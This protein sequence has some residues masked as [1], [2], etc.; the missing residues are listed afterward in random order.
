[1]KYLFYITLLIL[2]FQAM[3]QINCDDTRI[4]LSTDI[5]TTHDSISKDAP[6]HISLFS[7]IDNSTSSPISIIYESVK[8][9]STQVCYIEGVDIVKDLA[10][11]YQHSKVIK[12]PDCNGHPETRGLVI[13]E[14]KSRSHGYTY[15]EE[16]NLLITDCGSISYENSRISQSC[17]NVNIERHKDT[18]NRRA[19]TAEALSELRKRSDVIYHDETATFISGKVEI[20]FH[21][22]ENKMNQILEDSFWIKV[23]LDRY[24]DHS[25][26]YHIANP[27]YD[28][29]IE[30]KIIQVLFNLKHGHSRYQVTD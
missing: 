8:D 16:C 19:D 22:A 28:P 20:E 13:I 2:P 14:N 29:D 7:Q 4:L 1:M 3:S 6:I 11:Q 5:S 15:I 17:K 10:N 27:N 24:A 12:E 23:A 18:L 30:T 21:D 25:T 26:K 9:D